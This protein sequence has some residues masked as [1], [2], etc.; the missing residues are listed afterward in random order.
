MIFFLYDSSTKTEILIMKLTHLLLAIFAFPF[1]SQAQVIGGMNLKLE[2]MWDKEKYEDIAYKGEGMVDNDKY[3]KNPEIYLW[4]SMAWYEISEINDPKMIEE[5]PKALDYGFKWAAKFRKK[6]KDGVMYEDNKDY[7]EDLKK[8][9]VSRAAEYE[10]DPKKLR[11]ATGIYK[12]MVRAVPDDFN[13]LYKKGVLEFRARNEAEGER[14][15]N[16]A[17]KG[18]AAAYTNKRYRPSKATAGVLED[19]MLEF[20]EMMLER[21]LKDSANKVLDWAALWFPESEKVKAKIEGGTPEE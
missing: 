9:G 11:K 20:S 7:F 3:K 8:A 19:S 21:S 17:M 1:I 14:S 12:Y 16:K 10:D 15:I 2:T 4:V 13:A 6:D 18:L 5:Y